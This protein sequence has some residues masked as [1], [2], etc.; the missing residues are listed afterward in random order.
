[1]RTKYHDVYFPPTIDCSVTVY[2]DLTFIVHRNGI[3]CKD[4]LSKVMQD[5]TAVISSFSD[6]VNLLSYLNGSSNDVNLHFIYISKVIQECVFNSEITPAQID[7][8]RFLSEQFHLLACFLL[9][10]AD[11]KLTHLSRA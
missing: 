1:M 10:D 8:L 2:S 4:D 7:T 5:S 6:F 3:K 11:I 9:I